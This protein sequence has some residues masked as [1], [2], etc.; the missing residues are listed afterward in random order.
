MMLEFFA[1]FISY[2]HDERHILWTPHGGSS[3][4][5]MSLQNLISSDMGNSKLSL[6]MTPLIKC[7]PV[8]MMRYHSHD[9]VTL[10][11]KIKFLDII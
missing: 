9:Y 7:E 10:Y 6:P 5:V 8:K 1:K 4:Y 2:C 3:S 11:G